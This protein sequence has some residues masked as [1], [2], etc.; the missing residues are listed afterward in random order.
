MLVFPSNPSPGEVFAPGPGFPSWVWDGEKWTRGAAATSFT[1]AGLG[2]VELTEPVAAGELLGFEDGAW[3]NVTDLLANTLS[4]GGNMTVHG[5]LT[6]GAD[7]TTALGAATKQYVDNSLAAAP[8]PT[9]AALSSGRLTYDGA[10]NVLAP[11]A[12]TGK[13]ALNVSAR[14]NEWAELVNGN[15]YGLFVGSNSSTAG[16]NVQFQNSSGVNLLLLWNDGSGQLASGAI[17]WSNDGSVNINSPTQLA[18]QSTMV[19][20]GGTTYFVGVPIV[21]YSAGWASLLYQLNNNGTNWQYYF[22]WPAAGGGQDNKI[23]RIEGPLGTYSGLDICCG[24][25]D[26]GAYDGRTGN[27]GYILRLRANS[28]SGGSRDYFLMNMWGYLQLPN[29]P[30][31]SGYAN[32]ARIEPTYGNFLSVTTSSARYKLD[33]KTLP[34]ARAR[35]L[36]ARLRPITFKSN[37]KLCYVGNEPDRIHY[38][39]VAEEV[40]AIDPALA[41]YDADGQPM[42]VDYQAITMLLIP[43]VRE[44]LGMPELGGA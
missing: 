44:L 30:V 18:V 25:T 19:V 43:L 14:F 13:G 2:D 38:G 4:V 24:Y 7:P 17:N 39:L 6:L 32:N 11:A 20:N 37:P 31:L 5:A 36:F 28:A 12:D 26:D 41:D 33:M 10:I 15:P 1:L 27:D 42:G 40:A 29:L 16:Y 35:E 3:R 22:G 23:M 8:L 34:R 9:L 21:G